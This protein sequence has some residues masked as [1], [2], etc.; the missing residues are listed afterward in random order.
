MHRPDSRLLARVG[1]ALCAP[2]LALA[3]SVPG[4]SAQEEFRWSG[5][6][7]RGDAVTVRGVNGEI[8]ARPAPDDQVVVRATKRARDDAPASVEIEVIEDAEGVLIC[9]VY[10]DDRGERPNRCARGDDYHMSTHDND[11]AVHFEV[12]VP[13]GVELDAR[14][15][16]GDV[17]ATGL[18]AR[19]RTSTVNGSI[20]VESR[21]VVSAHTVNGSIDASMG[22]ADW[23]GPLEFHTVNGGITLRVPEGTG[24]DIEVETVNGDLETDFPLTIEGR[25]RWGPKRLRGRIGG[26]GQPLELHTVNGS[27]RLLRAS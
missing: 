25:L 26:G 11:V 27:I 12:G 22:S 16:N 10:P 13:S 17:R 19:V 6:V 20:R 14:T 9:A 24:A 15:V 18:T 4:V 2:V 23:T 3:F 7:E 5:A 1:L 8:V 21:G